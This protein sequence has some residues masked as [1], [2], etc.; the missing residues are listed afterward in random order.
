MGEP[1]LAHR[2]IQS[3][4]P[5]KAKTVGTASS[6][7]GSSRGSLH[8]SG[9]HRPR[10]STWTLDVAGNHS[11]RSL[12]PFSGVSLNREKSKTMGGGLQMTKRATGRLVTSATCLVAGKEQ[13][14]I[15]RDTA[16]QG[17]RTMSLAREGGGRTGMTIWHHHHHHHQHRHQR[18]RQHHD[19]AMTFPFALSTRKPREASSCTLCSITTLKSL[20]SSPSWG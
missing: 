19:D 7:R 8:A 12:P 10:D 6:K 3:T 5:W 17:P 2:T 11:L 9:L 15:K 14:G 18:Q 1:S 4:H 13:T 20:R 16:C